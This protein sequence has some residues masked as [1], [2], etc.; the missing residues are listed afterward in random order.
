MKYYNRILIAEDD[1][2]I[3]KLIGLMLGMSGLKS[4]LASDGLEALSY[5][6]RL[7]EKSM[8]Y[9]LICTDLNM[10]NLD[11]LGLITEISKRVSREEI[12]AP[13]IAIL[14][15]YQSPNEQQRLNT[16]GNLEIK[17]ILKPIVPNKFTTQL[18][19]LYHK[20]IA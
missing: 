11:G 15:G 10:P 9:P 3:R 14:T 8:S 20:A 7:K 16:F 17:T 12:L 19:D 5:I 4:D 18:S 13:N 1:A 6:E 2:G